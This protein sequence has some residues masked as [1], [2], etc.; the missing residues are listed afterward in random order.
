[1]EVTENRAELQVLNLRD[2]LQKH[3]CQFNYLITLLLF[4]FSFYGL[5]L[6]EFSFHQNEF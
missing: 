6:L 1:M 2:M 4:F 5:W 3:R